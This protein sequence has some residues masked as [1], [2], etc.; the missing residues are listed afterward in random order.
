MIN[1][2]NEC[3]SN[4]NFLSPASSRTINLTSKATTNHGDNDNNNNN[5]NNNNNKTNK[6]TFFLA[7]AVANISNDVI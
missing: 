2:Y 3:E 6:Q 7:F 1:V 5:N 4:V